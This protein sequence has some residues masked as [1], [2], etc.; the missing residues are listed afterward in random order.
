[1]LGSAAVLALL[2]AVAFAQDA[3]P[4]PAPAPVANPADPSPR[5][6]G[7]GA[8]APAPAG[9][10]A[11][12]SAQEAVQDIVVTG[13]R[14]KGSAPV[15]SPIVGLNRNDLL[16]S[17]A[18]NTN[19]LVQELPQITNQ[20]VSES[21]R[22]TSGGSGNITYGSGFNIHGIGPYAT[23]TLL[24]GRRIVVSGASG[25]IPDPNDIP[26]IAIQRIDVVAD[27][28]SAIY[29]SDA[30]AGVVNLI[31]RR[32]FDG[33]ETSAHYG[34]ADDYREYNAA[35]IA[36]KSWSTGNVTVAYEHAGH[37]SLSGRYR[38]FYRGDLTARGGGDYRTNQCNPGNII[39]GGTS[40]A[41]PGLAAGTV[42]KCDNLKS[43][44]LIPY[45]KRD[46]VMAAATQE[47]GSKLTLTLDGFYSRRRFVFTPGEQAANLTVPASNAYY[48]L[49]AGVV[50][51]TETVAYSFAG[52]EPPNTSRG[53]SEVW[54][55]S[56]GAAWKPFGDWE[57]D[58]S[59][60]YGHDFS[61]SR[62]QLGVNNAALAAALRSGNPATAL[63]PYG[64]ANNRAV[65]DAIFNQIFYAPGTN[66]EHQGS[67]SA[68]G[69]LFKLP[70][71][72][73]RLAIGGEI[74]HDSILTGT[75][76]GPPGAVVS[77][78]VFNSRTIKSVF[79]ELLVPV[80]GPDNALP[81]IRR[82]DLSLAGRISDYSDVGSSKNPKIGLNWSPVEGLTLHGSYGKSF[83]APNL[84]Q[85]TGASNALYVQNYQTPNGVV[86]GVTL[87]G[88]K[89]GNTLTPE[90]ARTFSF[91]G[92]FQPRFLPGLKLSANYFNVRYT[93]QVQSILADL[94][95]LQNAATTA[96]YADRIVQ[97][98]QAAALVQQFVAQGYQVFGVL[99][100]NPTLFVYGNNVNSGITKAQGI[101]FQVAYRFGEVTVGTNGTRF[102]KFSTAV[103]PT[104]PLL[105]KL[106][107]IFY[108]PKFRT[109]SSVRWDHDS[110]NA[111]AF[112][113]YTG[114]INNDRVTP[115]QKVKPYATVD[116]HLA[117]TWKN[118]NLPMAKA[119]TFAF[120]ATNLFD[121][122]PPFVDISQSSNGGGGFDPTTT[123]PIGRL[124]A[125]TV[126]TKF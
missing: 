29:G 124:L 92:D 36:G 90:H 55:V 106:N 123:N 89:T 91:G 56:A 51:P 85:I 116:L 66:Q 117:Y 9:A 4:V 2:P 83:R 49:P 23:L 102:T 121:R 22:A 95:I 96:Q 44:D 119:V 28:A 75:D 107:S 62:S 79:G 40:Y 108:P 14:I 103:S 19:Q 100:A 50:A 30:V 87:S 5:A 33:L 52:Q 11:L 37:S 86:Q 15:G 58:A 38:D 54:Q 16:Q 60:T 46:S 101:D 112:L 115:T 35:F 120:D 48:T 104:A 63:N 27:G 59:Y 105:D 10:T 80:V 45:Q 31:T 81:G 42:N 111:A 68:N 77:N 113:N 32:R 21:S 53:G 6:N 3:P 43:S 8:P 109:R 7:N 110:F 20:G 25:G 125:L 67:L 97:G 39:I 47:I 1:M 93:G 82:L 88:I 99:P 61:S 26:T 18:T 12:P 76:S 57:V 41:L 71:G 126:S 114:G 17:G 73:V 118:V 72:R 78:R 70:G 13:S 65:L 94:T 122:D 98:A 34:F 74:I 24:N 69:S 64:G 84:T